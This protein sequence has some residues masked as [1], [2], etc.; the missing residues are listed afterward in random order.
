MQIAANHR[1]VNAW[2]WILAVAL[3][4]FVILGRSLL[5]AELGWMAVVGIVIYAAPTILALLLPPVLTRFD[6]QAREAE[7]IRRTYAIACFV[8]WGGLVLAGLS[9]PDSGD[10]GHLPSVVSRWFGLSYEVSEVIFYVAL[11][12]A[13]IAWAISLAVAA[14]GVAVSRRP[15]R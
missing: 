7:G 5:G 1:W 10:N 14:S 15:A 4:A 3:P 12:T 9:I 6:R 8:L 13:V 2:Q 11:M